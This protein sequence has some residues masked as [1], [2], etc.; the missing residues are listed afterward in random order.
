MGSQVSR[1]KLLS[2][3]EDQYGYNCRKKTECGL[4]NK[5]LTQ[6]IIYQADVLN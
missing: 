2:R 3:K 5:C 4:D 6:R 1:Q